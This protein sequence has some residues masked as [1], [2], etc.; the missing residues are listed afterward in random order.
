MM[1][2]TAFSFAQVDITGDWNGML[3]FQGIMK[4][5][6]IFHIQ[7]KDGAYTA[8]LDSPDQNAY[9]IPTGSVVY[10]F[11][12][13]EI[14]M[15]DLRAHFKGTLVHDGTG[16][17]GTFTQA[18]QALLLELGR[19]AIEKEVLNRPQEPKPPFPYNEEEVTFENKA[20]GITLAGTLTL[21]KK[22]GKCPVVILVSGSGPQDRN[23]E[24]LGHKP[25]LVI[26]DHLTR[27]GIG[28][29]RYDDRGVGKS[30]GK[31]STATSKDFASDALAAVD[32]LRTRKE[33][34]K[35]QIGIA[36]HSEGGLIAPMCAAQSKK[37]AFIILL[38]GPG[39]DGE[40]VVLT[41]TELIDRAEGYSDAKIQSD[42]EMNRKAFQLMRSEPDTA[43]L[44][45]QLVALF[46]EAIKA[47]PE[48]ERKEI[49]DISAYANQQASQ[50]ASPWFLYFLQYDPKTALE[51]VKCPVL[52]LNGEKDL[53]VEP[54]INLAGIEEALKKGGNKHY[55]IEELPG[56]NHL[57]QECTTG[58]PT[59]YARIEQTFSPQALKLMSDW[60]WKTVGK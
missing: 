24:L 58:S 48:E 13:L 44:R 56:L 20:A 41:Q 32:Y 22:E 10:G 25:F 30:T 21:P 4:M 57:F 35:K 40:E 18:G 8:T 29:L 9:G 11:P 5:R 45:P 55:Q 59:E 2:S 26:A 6:I 37:V 46:E 27:Q 47:M 31:F 54:K 17:S 53:Q 38:A 34:D 60:I 7:E 15:P 39:V 28:V 23:E 43:K 36:G 12:E 49:G 33:I 14:D 42:L 1:L 50:L 3:D 51:K 16:I 19:K 52:A